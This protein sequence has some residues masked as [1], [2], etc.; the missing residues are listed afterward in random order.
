MTT[1]LHPKIVSRDELQRRVAAWRRA[2]DRVTLANGCFDV[3]HVGH[4]RYLHIARELGGKLI[5][6]VNADASV[7]ALKGEGRPV[8]PADERAE[9]LASLADVDAVVVFPETDVRAIIREV[10]PDFHAKGTDYNADTVPERDE[11]EACGGRVVIVGDPKDHSATEIIA[12]LRRK[13]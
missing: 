5:V 1:S 13:S 10:R 3:L 4:V 2:G 9:I 8:M 7:R 6:A 12:R 11:V